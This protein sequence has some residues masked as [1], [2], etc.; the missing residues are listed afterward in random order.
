MPV[1]LIFSGDDERIKL[2]DMKDIKNLQ[3]KIR[4]KLVRD[5]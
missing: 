4:L 1:V 5:Q 2:H 3:E